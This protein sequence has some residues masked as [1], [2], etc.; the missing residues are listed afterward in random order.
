MC[1]VKIS[2]LDN[3]YR[4]KILSILIWVV[5]AANVCKAFRF[6]QIMFS[7][8]ISFHLE[9]LIEL[10]FNHLSDITRNCSVL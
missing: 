1:G 4:K 10:T 7:T 8:L 6:I 5:S 9:H 2:N 3:A